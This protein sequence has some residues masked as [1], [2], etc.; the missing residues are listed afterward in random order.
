MSQD[1]SIPPVPVPPAGSGVPP[2]E[3]PPAASA[4]PQDPYATPTAPPIAQGAYGQPGY[5]PPAYG[6]PPTGPPQGLAIASM[7][8]GIVGLLFF[9][10]GLLISVA[11]VILGHLA[12]QRQAYARGF[13]I[14]GLI[15]GY[16]G[17]GLAL[18]VGIFFLFFF[19]AVF[20]AFS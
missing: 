18:I 7:V 20:S 12:Q 8:C 4:A 16:V 2:V 19:V 5:P 1:D 17:V 13:W 15:T 11:A 6:A 3:P 10:F 14:T 9:G